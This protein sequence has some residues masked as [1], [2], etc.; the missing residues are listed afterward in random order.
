MKWI[1]AL[2]FAFSFNSFA[3]ESAPAKLSMIPPPSTVYKTC[4]YTTLGNP[5]GYNIT[6]DACIALW[7]NAASSWN[8]VTAG[9]M[10]YTGI[11]GVDKTYRILLRR[12]IDGITGYANFAIA[13]SSF[14]GSYV[15]PPDSK[16][17]FTDG[18]IDLNGTKVCQ[19]PPKI[20]KMGAIVRIQSDGKETCV[21]N[22][23]AAAGLT[24][25]SQY[26][27]QAGPTAGS[28]AGEVTCFGQ[29][30][31]KTIGGGIQLSSGAWTGSY[32]FTGATCPTVRPEPVQSESETPSAGTTPTPTD[33]ST[34]S[35]GTTGAL[36]QL[37]GAA[38]SATGTPVQPTATG[39]DNTATLKDVTKTIADSANAQI[40]ASSAQNAATGNLM[41]NISKDIQNAIIKSA[42]GSVGG[43]GGGGASASLQSQGNTK[44]DG[45]KGALDGISDKLDD[46]KPESIIF[47]QP[48]GSGA[49]WEDVIPDSSFDD[50]KDKRES[51]TQEIKDL[52]TSFQSS[53]FTSNLTASGQPEEWTI[54]WQGQSFILGFGAFTLALNA[55]LTAIILLICAMTAVYI[56]MSRK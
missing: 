10:E 30:S 38:S 32:T 44:L 7:R 31:I 45:I 29:C 15:C 1:F 53:V 34:T 18:P 49:F 23:G 54:N 19:V 9:S 52:A 43:G 17:T 37:A 50:M 5:T 25:S 6:F 21:P 26:Y 47:T 8:I 16:P 56:M 4:N 51:A 14:S 22:C 41:S 13:S 36:D 33:E 46:I 11:S 27:F 42:S 28:T 2:L 20:C 12:N 39:P 24:N 35:P 3:V 55:G 40:K 48:A